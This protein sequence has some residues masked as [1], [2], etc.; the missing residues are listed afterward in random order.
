MNCM[1]GRL[2]LNRA[3]FKNEEDGTSVL[4]VCRSKVANS[5]FLTRSVFF[6]EIIPTFFFL[7]VNMAFLSEMV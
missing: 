4:H 5:L 3:V 6:S 2:Y 7:V 1:I